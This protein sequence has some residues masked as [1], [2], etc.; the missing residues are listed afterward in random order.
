MKILY[1][2]PKMAK[3]LTPRNENWP[4]SCPFTGHI[5]VLFCEN[6]VWFHLNGLNLPTRNEHYPTSFPLR[7]QILV[8]FSEN[9]VWID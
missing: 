6:V 2:V 4:G 5:L 9:V 3:N 7:G 1:V 8:V